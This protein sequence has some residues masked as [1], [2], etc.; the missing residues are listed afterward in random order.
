MWRNF[1]QSFKGESPQVKAEARKTLVGT[2]GMT[3]LLAG[4][5]GLPLYG[6]MMGAAKSLFVPPLVFASLLRIHAPAILVYPCTSSLA[7]PERV[8]AQEFTPLCSSHPEG[9]P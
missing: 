5:A 3:G 2:L 4:T 8:A 1:Y 7:R 9:P 6:V